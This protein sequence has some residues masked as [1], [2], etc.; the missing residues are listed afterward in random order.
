MKAINPVRIATL[1]TAVVIGAAA[2]A[3]C[4]KDDKKEPVKTSAEKPAEP[5]AKQPAPE[6]V[7]P[8]A[9]KPLRVEKAARLP[10]TNETKT[11]CA[12]NSLMLTKFS[13]KEL[14]EGKYCD[15]CKE[16]DEDACGLDWPSSDMMRCEEYDVMRNGI[17]AAYGNT[18]AK[19]KWQER[20]AK[21]P[22]YKATG[23]VDELALP[24]V[25]Q[26]NIK[27]LKDEAAACRKDP[28]RNS[29]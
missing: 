26:K 21:E 13:F 4:A 22:W 18:F 11:M 16:F 23:K 10:G 15:E 5:A 27:Y 3:G 14:S 17:Y 7:K 6:P 29:L 19:K 28:D 25:A 1:I 20:F 24:V 2:T 9:Q 12:S 8:I